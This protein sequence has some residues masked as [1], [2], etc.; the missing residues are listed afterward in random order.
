[1]LTNTFQMMTYSNNSPRGL[2][3]PVLRACLPSILSMVEY[4]MKQS[5]VCY[6]PQ[7]P[8]ESKSYIHTPSPKLQ[9]TQ[10]GAYVT[11]SFTISPPNSSSMLQ[12][13]GPTRSGTMTTIKATFP[14]I[15]MNPMRVTI[16]GASH[17]GNSSTHQFHCQSHHQCII[18]QLFGGKSKKKKD[19]VL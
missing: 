7:T 10:L 17:F 3:V 12:L 2:D 5:V 1:M 13:T 11:V 19:R 16:F 8:P 15:N 4:L 18:L 6:L 14:R 9:Y